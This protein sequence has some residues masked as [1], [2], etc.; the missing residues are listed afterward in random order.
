MP[1]PPMDQSRRDL[2]AGSLPALAA[3]SSIPGSSAAALPTGLRPL[4]QALGGGLPAH[5][6]VAVTV[7]TGGG[8]TALTTA[9]ALGAARGAG[10]RVVYRSMHEESGRVVDALV[11]RQLGVPHHRVRNRLLSARDFDR[12]RDAMLALRRDLSFEPY[13]WLDEGPRQPLLAPEAVHVFDRLDDLWSGLDGPCCWDRRAWLQALGRSAAETGSLVIVVANAEWPDDE[14]TTRAPA[15]V[16]S[17]GPVEAVADVHLRFGPPARSLAGW[18]AFS[19]ASSSGLQR[20]ELWVDG[21]TKRVG[22]EPV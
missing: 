2:T 6:L 3:P 16:T 1:S 10:R 8:Q 19:V 12:A 5:G 21:V 22:T 15:E 11:S 7:P 20:G 4:D 13:A 18:M 17:W 14:T 9:I